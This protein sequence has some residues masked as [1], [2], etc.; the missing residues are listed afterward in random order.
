MKDIDGR[1]EKFNEYLAFFTKFIE[2]QAIDKIKLI[3]SRGDNTLASKLECMEW[4]S[5]YIKFTSPNAIHKAISEWKKFF[6]QSEPSQERQALA[7]LNG[8]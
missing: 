4:M 7:T 2:E 6:M 8:H 3:R 5:R 1:L